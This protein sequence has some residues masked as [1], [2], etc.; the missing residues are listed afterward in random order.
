MRMFFVIATSL[1]LI[2]C[3]GPPTPLKPTADDGLAIM[4]R[5]NFESPPEAKL[6][7]AQDLLTHAEEY[8]RQL[9]PSSTTETKMEAQRFRRSERAT[10]AIL[11]RDAGAD[12][13]RQHETD[14]AREVYRSII[15]TFTGENEISF[16]RGAEAALQRVNEGESK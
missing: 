8:D 12:Y 15:T 11:M 13:L 1:V 2:A 14:K 9:T 6:R 10:A 3:A 5:V 4:K 7:T 16:R